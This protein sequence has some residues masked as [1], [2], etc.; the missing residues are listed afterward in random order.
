MWDFEEY[1]KPFTGCCSEKPRIFQ[2]KEEGKIIASQGFL[3]EAE[4]TTPY[5]L[6]FFLSFF[7]FFLSFSPSFPPSPKK[8]SCLHLCGVFLTPPNVIYVMTVSKS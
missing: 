4:R 1:V 6:L 3:T 5:P 2:E 7:L 8:K